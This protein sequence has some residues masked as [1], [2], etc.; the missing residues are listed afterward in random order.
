M[1]ATF[2][3]VDDLGCPVTRPGLPALAQDGQ[4]GGA[5]QDIQC[6]RAAL[7]RAATSGDKRGAFSEGFKV[8]EGRSNRSR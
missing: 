7:G 2:S 4:D 8:A 6:A 5:G 3:Q 1:N